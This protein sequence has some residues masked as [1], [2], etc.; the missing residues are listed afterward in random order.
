MEDPSNGHRHIEHFKPIHMI[1]ELG[2][3]EI[4]DEEVTNEEQNKE[5][6]DNNDI[7]EIAKRMKT[8]SRKEKKKWGF[9][10]KF[11]FLEK[12]KGS[13]RKETKHKKSKSKHFDDA[14]LSHLADGIDIPKS[15]S[16]D[17]L[18]EMMNDAYE[19]NST[20]K[21]RGNLKRTESYYGK[22]S[23]RNEIKL[24]SMSLRNAS[25]NTSV[26]K[27]HEEEYKESNSQT[28]I[29]SP[30]TKDDEKKLKKIKSKS[31]N[32]YDGDKKK[33][34]GRK[35]SK[36]NIFV[37][38]SDLG[39]MVAG[40][41]FD[42]LTLDV[43]KKEVHSNGLDT[44]TSTRQEKQKKYLLHSKSTSIIDK[45]KLKSNKIEIIGKL[46]KGSYGT[47]WCGILNNE[48]VAL[49]QID[50]STLPEKKSNLLKKQIKQE[51]EVLKSLEDENII[52]YTDLFY[53]K[54]K[55]EINVIMELVEGVSLTDLVLFA[56]KL[57]EDVSACMVKQVLK[58]LSYLHEHN[59][60]HR[61]IK[62][63]N[64]LINANCTIKIIDFGTATFNAKELKRRSTVGT[65]WYC[66]PEVINTDDYNWSV[67]I[68][69][70]GCMMLELITGKPPYD[71]LNS[72]QCLYKMAESAPPVP[73]E[74]TPE[75]YDFISTCLNT[76][77]YERPTAK[78][79]LEHPYIMINQEKEEGILAY[80]QTVIE[81]IIEN[82]KIEEE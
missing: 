25:S 27:N 64:I 6:V 68:W 40:L 1:L 79:L 47:V 38:D 59:L 29:A 81:E 75:C 48:R 8:T 20:K 14:N 35:G 42:N 13:K 67:D 26:G 30:W 2:S 16:Q 5:N 33:K 65:P 28:S 19:V 71:E 62:P 60:I 43:N 34:H 70:L 7:Q 4:S 45:Q 61:D 74:I 44:S 9:F 51:V 31:K 18:K 32:K 78:K 52:K 41:D 80:L 69:S 37:G 53:N 66:A 56:T 57:G 23:K 50:F 72:I 73:Q 82:N 10:R 22:S 21:K 63:D 46:G 15:F 54:M 12:K 36:D 76:N 17:N 49:K 77:K 55:K 24:N 58:G 3:D 11:K 39:N